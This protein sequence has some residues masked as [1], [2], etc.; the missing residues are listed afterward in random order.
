M[1]LEKWFEG[2]LPRL[3]KESLYTDIQVIDVDT[4]EPLEGVYLDFWHGKFVQRTHDGPASLTV[5]FIANSTGVYSGVVAEGNGNDN[6]TENINKTFLRGL[7]PTSEDGAAQF[8]S[9]FPGY[10]TDRAIHIHVVVHQNATILPNN[11]LV[12]GN[13]SY[14]GQFGYDQSLISAVSETYPYTTNYQVLTLNSEDPLL[15]F[16]GDEGFDPFAEYV[17]LG[18]DISDGI[19]SWISFA[20]NTSATNGIYEAAHYEAGEAIVSNTSV[21]TSVYIIPIATTTVV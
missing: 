5:R 10:Y 15:L 1:S 21:P 4:C 9:I 2:I 18:D 11:T 16:E 12:G 7:Q 6:D 20:V 14:I 3:K 13:I 19:L 17:L 8:S